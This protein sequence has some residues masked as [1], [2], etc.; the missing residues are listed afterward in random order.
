MAIKRMMRCN[1]QNLKKNILPYPYHITHAYCTH[2]HI[3]NGWMLLLLHTDIFFKRA[4]PF[5]FKKQFENIIFSVFTWLDMFWF[6][7]F[8]CK[9]HPKENYI[10]YCSLFLYFGR[11]YL[12]TKPNWLQFSD[13]SLP[14]FPLRKK[15]IWW[16]K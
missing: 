14:D 12:K 1:L 7:F 11:C 9:N 4:A 13:A 8:A 3:C 6:D 2:V 10:F 5:H 15:I 16:I